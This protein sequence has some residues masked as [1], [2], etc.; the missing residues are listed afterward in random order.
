VLDDLTDTGAVVAAVHDVV[1]SAANG[2][3]TASTAPPSSAS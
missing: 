1:R 2:P 3:R